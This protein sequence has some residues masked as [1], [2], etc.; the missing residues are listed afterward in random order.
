MD[1][2]SGVARSGQMSSGMGIGQQ[3]ISANT[4]GS[5]TTYSSTPVTY[6]TPASLAAQPQQF[7]PQQVPAS[8]LTL[9][10]LTQTAGLLSFFSVIILMEGM[11][12]FVLF[13]QPPPGVGWDGDSSNFPTIAL[14]LAGLF[15]VCF[16]MMGL[17]VGIC[18]MVFGWGHPS[19]TMASIWVQ[20]WF[21]LY[22]Y[23]VM[24]IAFPAWDEDKG[25]YP[26][27]MEY[28]G[29]TRSQHNTARVFGNIFG[30][31]SFD[32]V[33]FAAQMMFAMQLYRLQT[34][35]A[36]TY[37]KFYYQTRLM[38]FSSLVLLGGLSCI[39]VGSIYRDDV[40]QGKY[41]IPAEYFPNVFRYPEMTIVSGCVLIVSGILGLA[42]AAGEASLSQPYLWWN[43][44]TW[45]WLIAGH[46]MGQL[47]IIGGPMA[48]A[49]GSLVVLVTSLMLAPSYL[50]WKLDESCRPHLASNK[51]DSNRRVN[52]AVS[53]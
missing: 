9:N 48:M 11:Q 35:Q 10:N 40:G 25:V 27:G 29:L 31:M 51:L 49:G 36:V 28:D 16:A 24:T 34:F 33:L 53:N 2:D 46:T 15:E 22:T 45:L 37:D 43:L 26:A 30:L 32:G 39:V 47:G 3:Q 52:I 19:F 4:Y 5:A 50:A 1:L 23:V 14:M 13:S 44:L 8:S 42:D 41:A 38:L 20:L 7:Y 17:A 18:A 12:R 6:N 21:G